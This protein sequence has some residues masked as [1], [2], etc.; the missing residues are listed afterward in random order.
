MWT[1]TVGAALLCLVNLGCATLVAFP[2]DSA[3]SVAPVAVRPAVEEGIDVKDSRL[4]IFDEMVSEPEEGARVR[5]SI[6]IVVPMEVTTGT[7]AVDLSVCGLKAWP[8]IRGNAAVSYM[9]APA[10]VVQARAVPPDT[11]ETIPV[12]ITAPSFD[13]ETHDL[14]VVVDERPLSLLATD[15]GSCPQPFIPDPLVHEIPVEFVDVEPG[16][17]AI[18]ASLLLILAVLGLG[19]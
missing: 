19:F 8:R 12:T 16:G 2:T 5:N 10:L 6:R 14:V 15:R 9:D 3:D 11:R 4:W 18:G 17:L 7:Q 1:R 13:P